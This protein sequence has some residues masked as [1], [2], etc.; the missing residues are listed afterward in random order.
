MPAHGCYSSIKVTAEVWALAG[1]SAWC[2]CWLARCR[3]LITTVVDTV[4][5]AI[6]STVCGNV[7]ISYKTAAQ[8]PQGIGYNRQVASVLFF[9]HVAGQ[10]FCSS[11]QSLH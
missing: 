2:C 10:G 6:S 3:E 9:V 11:L 1:R 7:Y 4:C 8:I 5:T